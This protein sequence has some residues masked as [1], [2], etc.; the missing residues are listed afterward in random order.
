MKFNISTADGYFDFR[1]HAVRSPAELAFLEWQ[2]QRAHEVAVP[3]IHSD[4]ALKSA[5]DACLK[6]ARRRPMPAGCYVTAGRCCAQGGAEIVFGYWFVDVLGWTGHAWIYLPEI[7][8]YADPTA[9]YA[10]HRVD[11][12]T[13]DDYRYL[14]IVRMDQASF[15]QLAVQ[16]GEWRCYMRDV[17]E[18]P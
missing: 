15:L 1:A 10:M 18:S 17:Y 12:R 2:R 7:E 3:S 14:E 8:S 6:R 9:D 13:A 5:V 16:H 11:G 4:P